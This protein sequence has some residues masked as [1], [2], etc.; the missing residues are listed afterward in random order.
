VNARGKDG[1]LAA[2]LTQLAG[3]LAATNGAD[4]PATAR[5]AALRKTLGGIAAQLR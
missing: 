1:A 3:G 5:V 2:Q 4:A